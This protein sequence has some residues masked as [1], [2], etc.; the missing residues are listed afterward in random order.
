MTQ[1]RH[2]VVIPIYKPDMSVRELY[3]LRRTIDILAVHDIYL[4]GPKKMTN[5]FEYLITKYRG[6]LHCKTFENHYFASIDGY[7]KL[8][9]SAL[10]Y[11]VFASYRYMLLVQTDALVFKDELDVWADKGYSYIG[12]PWF[13][14]FTKPTAPLTLTTVGNGGYSL[15]NIGDFLKVLSKPRIFKNT[16]MQT[17][18]GNIISN[19]YRYLKDYHSFIYQ[20]TQINLKVNEDVFWGLFVSPQCD[21]FKV[22]MPQ[23]AIAFAFEAHP[24]LL[25]E[26]NGKKLPF[27]CHAWER[28]GEEFWLKILSQNGCDVEAIKYR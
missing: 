28:Y 23:E 21:F 2:V 12:A 20:N 8:M 7:N 11:Q 19:T 9:L 17:W 6:R 16:L 25:Y 14:G 13:E 24:E 1:S 27:G 22:P 18:P 15:R 26:L 10:F 5:F 4:V 3:S